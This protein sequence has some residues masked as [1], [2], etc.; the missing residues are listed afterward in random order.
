MHVQLEVEVRPGE[1]QAIEPWT[2][3][4]ETGFTGNPAEIA[5]DVAAVYA[6]EQAC[7]GATLGDLVRATVATVT[8]DEGCF[9][10]AEMLARAEARVGFDVAAADATPVPLGA[11]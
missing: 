9:V 3:V 11:V 7:E 4:E 1:W 6:R 2:P 10:S 5:A 8:Y